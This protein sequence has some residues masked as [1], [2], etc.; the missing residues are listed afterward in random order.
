MNKR[1]RITISIG[2]ILV[3]LSGLFPSCEGKFQNRGLTLQ[4]NLGYHFLF[5]PPGEEAV[6]EAFFNAGATASGHTELALFSAH[7]IT[8]RV[9]IQF[10]TIVV[11]TLG[12][13]VLVADN[14]NKAIF[15]QD[16]PSED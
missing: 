14:K 15:D 3:I 2:V 10:F 1:Q 6:R 9:W 4:Q 16:E 12:L 5:W 13:F 11:T 7:I 8:S